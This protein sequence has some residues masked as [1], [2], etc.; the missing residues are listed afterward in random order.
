M[1]DRSSGLFWPPRALEIL[2]KH[3]HTC[4]QNIQTHFL[5]KLI[6]N[7]EKQQI[8]FGFTYSFIKVNKNGQPTVTGGTCY[9][10]MNW[11]GILYWRSLSVKDGKEEIIPSF[12]LDS[13]MTENN[14]FHLGLSFGC[15]KKHISLQWIKLKCC[16][17]G[18]THLGCR[19]IDCRQECLLKLAD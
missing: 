19:I 1:Q 3:L 5:K 15:K 14:S 11:L 13:P 6:M 2:E 4:R 16:I 8:Q 10:N 12:V 18:R 7:N 9:N 17:I